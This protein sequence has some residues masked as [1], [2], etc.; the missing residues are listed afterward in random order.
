[1]DLN[2]KSKKELDERDDEIRK[3][4][5]RSWPKEGMQGLHGSLQE[6]VWGEKSYAKDVS[7]QPIPQSQK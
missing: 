6:D 4:F 1:M 5:Y 3:S 2:M 7:L